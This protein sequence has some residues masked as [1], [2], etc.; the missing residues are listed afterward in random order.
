MEWPESSLW[1]E[2]KFVAK[3]LFA[4]IN[5]PTKNHC[6]CVAVVMSFWTVGITSLCRKKYC[7]QPAGKSSLNGKQPLENKDVTWAWDQPTMSRGLAE[8]L[9]KVSVYG[10]TMMGGCGSRQE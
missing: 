8:G 7:K 9:V 6:N 2:L 4:P 3:T 1:T 5:F 10:L